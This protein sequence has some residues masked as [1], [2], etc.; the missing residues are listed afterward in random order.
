MPQEKLTIAEVIFAIEQL[1]PPAYQEAWDNSG[2]LLGEPNS[3]IEAV[4]I[5]LDVTEAVVDEAIEKGAGLIVAHHPII[6]GGLKRLTGKNYVER[7]VMKALRNRIGIYAA[8]TNLDHAWE[9]LNRRL[10]DKLKLTKQEVLAPIEKYLYKLV[11]FVP[12]SHSDQLRQ[13]IFLTGAGHI[14]NYDCCSYSLEGY[15]T[16]RA[17][18]NTQPFVGQKG[19][20]HTEKELRLETIV[21]KHL[22]NS[23]ISTIKEVHPYEEVAYDVY[24]LNNSFERAGAGMF[25]E[26]PQAIDE[27]DFLEKIKSLFGATIRH[28]AL[29]GRPIQKVALCGGA[30]AF[31][32]PKAIQ[33]QADIFIS[34]DFKYHQFFDTDGRILVADIGHYESEI[35]AKDIFYDQL[36]KKFPNFACFLSTTNTNPINYL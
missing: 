12:Q 18:E 19:E 14:G 7:I 2:L 28:T 30:G 1:A 24:P 10:A 23:V 20:I 35:L 3:P 9:G 31:L 33:K 34:A 26:L 32:L 15:G 11:T 27:K 22:I 8:H 29:L 21:P 25:G 5:T 17:S 16:F 6:F 4:L 13:A 36:T